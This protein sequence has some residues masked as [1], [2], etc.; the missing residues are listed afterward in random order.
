VKQE[1]THGD[2]ESSAVQ[3]MLINTPQSLHDCS[4]LP[5][6][7]CCVLHLHVGH[8]T[9]SVNGTSNVARRVMY[10]Y[11]L[12][13]TTKEGGHRCIKAVVHGAARVFV[14]VVMAVRSAYL[15]VE[16]RNDSEVHAVLK[17]NCSVRKQSCR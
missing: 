8:M 17:A 4:R 14:D 16:T 2:E 5:C 1:P 9:V 13:S 12:Q 11:L 15:S 3:G 6:V 7:L 10:R